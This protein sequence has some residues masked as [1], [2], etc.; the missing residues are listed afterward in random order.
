MPLNTKICGQT[1]YSKNKEDKCLTSNQA[2]YIYNKVELGSIINTDTIKQEMEQDLDRLDDTS[3][4]INPYSE[5]IVNKAERDNTILS[6]ME[7]W[8]ILSNIVNYVQ[9]HRHPKDF[10]NLDIKAIAHKNHKKNT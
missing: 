9:Y 1:S 2:K 7:H 6:K 3:G 4:E 10:Y 5:I 8:S